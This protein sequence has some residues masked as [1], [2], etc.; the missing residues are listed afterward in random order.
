MYL[1]ICEYVCVRIDD[2]CIVGISA[3]ICENMFV[4]VCTVVSMYICANICACMHVY[5][6]VCVGYL[7]VCA[8]MYVSTYEYIYVYLYA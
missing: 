3:C 6:H 4:S 7:S 1:Y 2:K 8:C 5:M